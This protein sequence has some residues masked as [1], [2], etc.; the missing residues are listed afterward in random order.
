M[1]SDKLVILDNHYPAHTRNGYQPKFDGYDRWFQRVN[2]RKGLWSPRP[3]L[4]IEGVDAVT[5]Q[6]LLQ[7][8]S[9]EG[10]IDQYACL[11]PK[12]TKLEEMMRM[13][14]LH[15][16]EYKSENNLLERLDQDVL[17]SILQHTPAEKSRV[18]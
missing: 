7:H 2:M 5:S 12:F 16:K 9:E 17:N 3:I 11:T 18:V 1:T 15:A 14:I 10:I 6:S 13:S 4:K 8:L